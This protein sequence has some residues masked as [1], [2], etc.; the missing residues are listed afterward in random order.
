MTSITIETQMTNTR[1]TNRLK[2]TV[3]DVLRHYGYRVER[4]VDY[5][6]HQV[7]V[8]DLAIAT[9][10]PE[11]PG[12]FFL[13]VGAHDGRTGDPVRR[14]VERYHWRGILLEPQPE[15]FQKLTQNYRHEPQ[16]VLENAALAF[17]DGAMSLYAIEGS[18]LR[19]SLNRAAVTAHAGSSKQIRELSVRAVTVGTLL[20]KHDV[21]RLDMLIVDTEGFD[22]QVVKMILTEGLRPRLIRYEHLHV[23]T[24][25]RIACTTMLVDAGYRLLRDGTDTLALLVPA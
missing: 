25:D 19:T 5:R 13:Q 20:R 23:S 21:G 9:L 3:N 12:F 10:Q 4:I 11:D 1:L 16:L 24:P 18:S 2:H 17:T 22:Y 7:D 15:V 6:K 8:L 14:F